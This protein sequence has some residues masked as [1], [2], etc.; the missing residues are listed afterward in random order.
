MPSV[1]ANRVFGPFRVIGRGTTRFEYTYGRPDA[2]E[3][4]QTSTIF[5]REKS[6]V[7]ADATTLSAYV[8]RSFVVVHI[9]GQYAPNGAAV[10][11]SEVSQSS[12][13]SITST[14]DQR[15][16]GEA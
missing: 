16:L 13:P 12:R 2:P 6:D 9:E 10:L 7:K 8:T 14:R 4:R 1:S 11:V 5:E 3:A 15:R